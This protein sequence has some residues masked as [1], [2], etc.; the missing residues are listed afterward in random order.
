[1]IQH[2]RILGIC[3]FLFIP[4]LVMAKPAELNKILKNQSEDK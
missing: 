2:Y 4:L 3:A 1:V